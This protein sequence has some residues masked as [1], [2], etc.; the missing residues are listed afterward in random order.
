MA[1]RKPT[2]ANPKP[3]FTVVPPISF[4]IQPATPALP[5]VADAK[6]DAEAPTKADFDT[7]RASPAG[8]DCKTCEPGL[9]QGQCA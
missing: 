7:I 2:T 6:T 3:T 9:R 8:A 5:E 1:V 4:R